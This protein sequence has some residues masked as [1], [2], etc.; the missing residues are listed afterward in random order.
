[1]VDT[2]NGIVAGYDGSP[3]SREAL[4]WAAWGGKGTRAGCDCHPGLRVLAALAGGTFLLAAAATIPQLAAALV[5]GFAVSLAL[6]TGLTRTERLLPGSVLTG[7]IRVVQRGHRDR[8]GV[9]KIHRRPRRGRRRP[10]NG[11]SGRRGRRAARCRARHAG[12]TLAEQPSHLR[13]RP[14]SAITT[15]ATQGAYLE[16]MRETACPNGATVTR[17]ESALYV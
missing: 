6:I 13:Q 10:T 14:G 3:G 2:V 17:A 8:P 16:D 12:P 7:G 15:A 9:R 4:D 1:V 11:V 5:A